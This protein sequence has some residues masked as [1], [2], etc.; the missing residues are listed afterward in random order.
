MMRRLFFLLPFLLPAC[1]AEIGDLPG[2]GPALDAGEAT[3]GGEGTD[4]GSGGGTG[5]FDAGTA[6]AGDAPDA[7][8]T[9]DAGGSFDAGT[10]VDAGVVDAG[11]AQPVFVVVG[12][13]GVRRRSTDLGLTWSA[14]QTLG[15]DGDNEFL[16]RAVTSGNGLFVAVGWKVLTSPDGLTWTERMNA[17]QQWLGGIQYHQGTFAAVGGYGYSAWSSDGLSWTAGTFRNAQAARTLAVGGNLLMAATDEGTWWR[18]SDGR[19]WTVD[20][21]GHGS[22]DVAWCGNQFQVQSACAETIVRGDVAFGQGVWLRVNWTA[23]ERS[24]D[25]THWTTVLTNATGL[26]GVTFGMVP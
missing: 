7:G 5:F 26:T 20:S 2:K 14:P 18:S 24:T 8:P 25:G 19:D 3:G 23:L 9:L 11:T 1:V 17:Q 4:S 6:D 22:P 15:A 13:A 10:D 21:T 16:L 12:Y